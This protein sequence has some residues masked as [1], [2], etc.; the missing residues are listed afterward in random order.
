MG[1][2]HVRDLLLTVALVLDVVGLF[3]VV[4][5]HLSVPRDPQLT[6]ESF[7]EALRAYAMQE[8]TI[9]N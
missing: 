6:L 9:S 4:M 8:S 1:V 7:R 2:V 5:G 3:A